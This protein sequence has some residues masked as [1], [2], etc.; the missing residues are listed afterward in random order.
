MKVVFD[1]ETDGLYHQATKIHCMS[2][3]VDDN[4]TE[5]YTSRPIK[6]SAGSI[7]DGLDIL[8]KADL[9]VIYNLEI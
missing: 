4:P 7:E 8:S 3:K 1:I 6:G 9:L 5:V 2:I